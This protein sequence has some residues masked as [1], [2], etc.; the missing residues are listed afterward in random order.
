MHVTEKLRNLRT[1]A[2]L[3]MNACAKALGF[4][5]PSSYQRYENPDLFKDEFLP[6]ELVRKLVPLFA[7]NGIPKGELIALTGLSDVT[8]IAQS[9]QEAAVPLDRLG[10]VVKALAE[11]RNDERLTFTPDEE[12]EMV[13]SFCRWY[14]T[15]IAAGRQTE[16]ITVDGAKSLLRLL[17]SRRA[18]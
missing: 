7:E 6:L 13:V 5:G 1:R 4:K 2:G 8:E 9:S 3:S 14:G 17:D 18:H 11:Y 16:P 12:A 10:V 15:E